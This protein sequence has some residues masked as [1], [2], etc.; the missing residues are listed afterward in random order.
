MCGYSVWDEAKEYLIGTPVYTDTSE[1]LIGM[2]GRQ[3][4]ELIEKHGTEKVMF[5][6]DYPLW[7]TRFAFD[8]IEQ[9]GLSEQ[10]KSIIYSENAKK[11][12]GL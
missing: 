3:L 6:S 2:D 4:Y 1:A 9:I 10:E 5:G 12:F 7:N 8:Q 11:V